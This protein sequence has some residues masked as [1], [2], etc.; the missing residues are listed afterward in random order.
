MKKVFLIIQSFLCVLLAVLLIIAVVVIYRSGA[1]AR[2]E[3]PLAAIFSREIAA[4]ALRA[5]AP[6]FFAA[7]GSA[8]V[9]MILGGRD[10]SSLKPVQ[11]GKVKN[12]APG[13][14][15]VQIVLLIAAV[16]LIAAGIFNGSAGDVFGKA[17]KICTECVG[18]G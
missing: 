9:G 12:K 10:R 5:T 18:L 13:G 15:T 4:E 14:R 2:A 16:V 1:A 3:D 8:A 6:L 7:V 17:V 11:G